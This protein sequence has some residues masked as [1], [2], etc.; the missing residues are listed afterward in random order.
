MTDR[1]RVLAHSMHSLNGLSEGDEPSS[2]SAYEEQLPLL[3]PVSSSAASRCCFYFPRRYI[4]V[5]L[6]F[7]ACLNAY[8]IRTLLSVAILPMSEEFEWKSSQKG[9]ILS[10]FFAGYILTQFPGG[11]LA[12]RFGAKHVLAFGLFAT[13]TITILTPEAARLSWYL[14]V[15]MRV[16]AGFAQ[17]ITFPSLQAIFGVWAP[18]K[19]RAI[20]TSMTYAGVPIGT[21]LAIG[22]GG[23][24]ADTDFLGGWPSIFYLFGGI[25]L[26]WVPAW[27]Y[28]ISSTPTLHPTISIEE[29]EY[30][31]AELPP[32]EKSMS[33]MDVPWKDIFTCRAYWAGFLTSVANAWSFYTLLTWLPTYFE[34]VL[35]TSVRTTGFLTIAPN[36]AQ[37]IISVATGILADKILQR[38][39]LGVT[40]VRK[41]SLTIASTISAATLVAC[42]FSESFPVVLTLMTISVGAIGI[43][44]AGSSVNNLDIAPNY[45]GVLGGI[46]NTAATVPGILSPTIT[47]L[48]LGE[49]ETADVSRWRI[50]FYIAAGFYVAGM[51]V[52]WMWASGKQQIPRPTTTKDTKTEPTTREAT[53]I[54]VTAEPLFLSIQGTDAYASEEV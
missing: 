52:W 2:L 41:L 40:A 7:F 37:T 27:L 46:T 22:G 9:I 54:I 12:S 16:L 14:L 3:K 38:G 15:V 17:G 28:F 44:A 45:A 1:R 30:L 8:A 32:R 21:C 33:L 31:N 13:A 18:P 26:L 29:R 25:G 11:Y 20:M 39:W 47:G 48:I 36:M 23:L 35:G 50:V 34:N 4:L 24:L 42:G 10:S 5:S 43:N 19:E 53:A 51:V 6:G 49:K